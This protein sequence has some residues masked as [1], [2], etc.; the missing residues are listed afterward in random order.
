MAEA[1]EN[2]ARS[3]GILGGYREVAELVQNA[4]GPELEERRAAIRERL[5]HEPSVASVSFDRPSA[6]EDELPQETV[7]VKPLPNS[8]L[9]PPTTLP[10]APSTTVLDQSPPIH[11]PSTTV[12]DQVAPAIESAPNKLAGTEPIPV[13]VPPDARAEAIR[14]KF[15]SERVVAET[16]RSEPADVKA[17]EE[18]LARKKAGL[19]ADAA[20]VPAPPEPRRA[21]T[22][23][24]RLRAWPYV[25]AIVVGAVVGIAVAVTAERGSLPA[26]TPSHR[27]PGH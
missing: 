16:L 19:A 25:V 26:S 4:V 9:G 12:P 22:A 10:R 23:K 15:G 7:R 8:S 5:A 1:L 17:I 6:G 14:A 27:G 24:R 13:E 21:R 3:A 18:W 11:A 20:D 2:A